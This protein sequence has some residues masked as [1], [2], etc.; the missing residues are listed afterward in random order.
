MHPPF[1]HTKTS[2]DCNPPSKEYT[3]SCSRHFVWYQF[4]FEALEV[5]FKTSEVWPFARQHRHT[6]KLLLLKGIWFGLKGV[7]FGS[8]LLVNLHQQYNQTIEVTSW[9]RIA[10][11]RAIQKTSYD[12]SWGR[13]NIWKFRIGLVLQYLVQ[14]WEI[15][16]MFM[17]INGVN[18]KLGERHNAQTNKSR[19]MSS[20]PTT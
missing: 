10:F 15:V 7:W 8:M 18:L 12:W 11:E 13:R 9:L 3:W 19:G 2:K 17:F 14:H 20:R 1:T 4:K 16:T 6:I 5:C